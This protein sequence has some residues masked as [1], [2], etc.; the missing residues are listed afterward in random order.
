MQQRVVIVSCYVVIVDALDCFIH[1]CNV[2][3]QFWSVTWLGGGTPSLCHWYI[4]TVLPCKHVYT[5]LQLFIIISKV[6]SLWYAMLF[7]IWCH[8]YNLKTTLSPATLLKAA[9]FHGFFS[10]L[11]NYANGSK[12]HKTSLM[13]SSWSTLSHPHVLLNYIACWW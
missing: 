5:P 11:L 8:L 9:L 4:S 6:S 13:F 12:L 10:G 1:F 7:A 2:N 3:S